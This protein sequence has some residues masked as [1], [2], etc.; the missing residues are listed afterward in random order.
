M[1]IPG[2]NI[3]PERLDFKKRGMT[4]ERIQKA[5]IPLRIGIGIGVEQGV[6][7]V[8]GERKTDFAHMLRG[9]RNV[10]N[11]GIA[12]RH[13]GALEPHQVPGRFWRPVFGLPQVH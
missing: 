11:G 5:F 1:P 4:W 6:V 12:S 9:V 3:S 7:H 10:H 13:Q 2:H 8:L